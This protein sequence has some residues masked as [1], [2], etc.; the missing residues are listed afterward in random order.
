MNYFC[1]SSQRHNVLEIIANEIKSLSHKTVL[2]LC[3]TRWSE[4]H[5]SVSCF[6][7]LYSA[8]VETLNELK[9]LGTKETSEQ[10]Y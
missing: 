5:G 4:K 2:G 8:I 7:E 3:K 6:V 9:E 10:V 1:L